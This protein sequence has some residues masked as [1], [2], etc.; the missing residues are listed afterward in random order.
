[1]LEGMMYVY[2]CVCVCVC[3]CVHACMCACMCV[4]VYA[5][6][7]ARVCACMYV[8]VCVHDEYLMWHM[9]VF[10]FHNTIYINH[11]ACIYACLYNFW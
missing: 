6:I 9:C 10:K 5:H 8:C 7:C 2:V 11:P 3:V 4:C 1:M